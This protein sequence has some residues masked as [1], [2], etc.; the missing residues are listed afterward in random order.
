MKAGHVRERSPGRWELRWRA[1]GTVRSQTIAAKSQRAA[2]IELAQRVAG[3][4]INAP[5]K[6]TVAGFLADWLDGLTIAPQTVANYRSLAKR[7]V[8]DLGNANVK[9]RELTALRIKQAFAEWS[10]TL[11]PSTLSQHRVVLRAALTDAVRYDMIARS[12]FDKLRGELPCGQPDEAKPTDAATIAAA[13]EDRESVYYGAVLLCVATGFGVSFF[14]ARRGEVLALQ[15]A[16]IDLAGGRVTIAR[17]LRPDMTFGPT[18]TRKARI[19]AL[20]A[21]AI[22]ALRIHRLRMVERLFALGRRLGDDDLVC[23]NR[24][25]KPIDPKTFSRAF[26]KLHGCKLHSTRHHHASALLSSGI[27]VKAVSA[28]LGHSSAKVTLAVYSHLLPG[29]DEAAAAAIEAAIGG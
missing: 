28:R 3:G 29:D 4:V 25:G 15:W 7:I 5:A 11:K 6:L 23:L 24:K 19:V 18:K 8:A 9:L 2:E 13:L 16:D 10:K 14:L 26:T 27:N 21:F 12:P 1:A 22:E 17:Q 20:P